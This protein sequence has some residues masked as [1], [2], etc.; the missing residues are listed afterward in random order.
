MLRDVVSAKIDYFGRFFEENDEKAAE[1]SSLHEQLFDKLEVEAVQVDKLK[2]TEYERECSKQLF[3]I[4][5]S[6]DVRDVDFKSLAKMQ[7]KAG[8]RL[9]DVITMDPPWILSSV[10]QVRGV[11]TNYST[12]NDNDILNEIPFKKL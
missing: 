5:V 12:L 10:K 9:F 3:C 8:G 2:L 1:K 4:P 6:L 11:K 7:L